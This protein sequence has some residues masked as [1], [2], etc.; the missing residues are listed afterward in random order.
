VGEFRPAKVKMTPPKTV[1]RGP[2]GDREA[3][4][5]TAPVT[6]VEDDALLLQDVVGNGNVNVI[7]SL[8]KMAREANLPR[9]PL[10]PRFNPESIVNDLRR[11]I[12][13]AET[14]PGLWVG[15]PSKD[16]VRKVDAAQVIRVLDNLRY[17]QIEMIKTLYAERLGRS[18]QKDPLEADLFEGGESG[19]P[20]TLKPDQVKRIKVLLQG[21][22]VD[23]PT[24]DTPENRLK[25][26]AIE[27]HELLNGDRD[28]PQL[29]RVMELLRRPEGEI[30]KIDLHYRITYEAEL[31]AVLEAKLS[32]PA[33]NRAAALRTGNLA[34]ADAWAIEEKRRKLMELAKAR[35][36]GVFQGAIQAER[37][38]LLAGIEEILELNRQEALRDPTNVG[39]SAAQAINDRLAA[40]LATATADQQTL[41]GQLSQTLGS[42]WV[43]SAVA[44]ADDG[45]AAGR[46]AARQLAA[47]E[48]M[49]TTDADKVSTLLVG[50]RE[51]ALHDVKARL[52]DPW[53]A[54]ADKEAIV[55]AG[56]GAIDAQV[57]PYIDEFVTHYEAIKGKGRPYD[58]IVAGAEDTY[59][60]NLLAAL[61]EGG[62]RVNPEKESTLDADALTV[63]VEA[64]NGDAVLAVLA[65]QTSREAVDVLEKKYNESHRDQPLDTALFG[66]RASPELAAKV[67]RMFTYAIVE[68]RT[69]T[70][71]HES[72]ER[73]R[74][75]GGIE[76]VAWMASFGQRE[77]TAAED[78]SGLI[79][80]AR[81]LWDDPETQTIMAESVQR[82]QALKAEW[83]RTADP[84]A[85]RA[86]PE[87]LAEM[88]RVRATLT[89]D[90]TAYESDNEQIAEQIRAAVNI[91]AQLA[92]AYFLPGLGQGLLRFLGSTAMNIGASVVVNAVTYRD[93]YDSDALLA[94]VSGGIFGTLGGVLGQ[95][96]LGRLAAKLA[97]RIEGATAKAAS[98]AGVVTAL[99]RE[100]GAG[101]RAAETAGAKGLAEEVG[102]RGFVTND[103]TALVGGLGLTSLIS[104]ENH[105]SAESLVVGLTASGAGRAGHRRQA[106]V[107]ARK[108]AA[109][110]G[111][112]PTATESPALVPDDAS[113]G[114][115]APIADS[116]PPE[117]GA[118]PDTA[119]TPE[120]PR[121]LPGGTDAVVAK[122]A[123]GATSEAASAE[124]RPS[125]GPIADGVVLERGPPV[126]GVG[127]NEV[128]PSTEAPATNE[129]RP[130]VEP[131]ASAPVAEQASPVGAPAEL[132]PAVEQKEFALRAGET[133]T[134]YEARLRAEEARLQPETEALLAEYQ[135]A[136]ERRR[137]AQRTVPSP[138]AEL[139]AERTA[140][141]AHRR[142]YNRLEDL[143]GR[144]RAVE[145]GATA[146]SRD[147]EAED[148]GKVDTCFA[149]GTPV[150][151]PGGPR[152]IES[153]SVNDEVLAWDDREG[154][155]VVRRVL[156]VNQGVSD[157]M[158]DVRIGTTRILATSQHPFWLA[159]ERAWRG[160]SDLRRGDVLRGVG[161]LVAVDS[162]AGQE[163]ISPTVNLHVDELHNYFAG[164]AG[165]LVHNGR[166][167]TSL[168][169]PDRTDTWIYKIEEWVAAG[170]YKTIYVGKTWDP[171]DERFKE[172][173]QEKSPQK[174]RWRALWEKSK[175]GAEPL[176]KATGI[177]KGKWTPAEVAVNER[178]FTE[179]EGG[180]A[181]GGGALENINEQ[182]S[183]DDFRALKRAGLLDNVCE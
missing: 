50:L 124:A 100:A 28:E 160:A 10:E 40:I 70:L 79:G 94:D 61:K 55:A 157:W 143:Q 123:I 57:Q 58:A 82:L 78:N 104:G 15:M 98:R 159:E 45:V 26:D 168:T 120:P 139:Q 175:P 85:P 27:L 153:L 183:N 142:A 156:A 60:R 34:A 18:H 3:R 92:L 135:K 11:A 6:V 129:A 69:A 9:P 125:T 133:L 39:K 96:V 140:Q 51:Q 116:L 24:G 93:R 150:H 41:G 127:P 174:A 91:A 13:Q 147:Y 74:V 83:I 155:T 102:L 181:N 172:H 33:R 89:G 101:V 177:R 137:K 75:L 169:S 136:L 103:V 81:G 154:R 63:A 110:V 87:I 138:A 164:E 23:W 62:G 90:A 162:V 99:S 165:V 144:L 180:R 12:D 77:R 14:I 118:L 31:S 115:S 141:L 112:P 53:L 163:T 80:W 152:A 176:I 182:I 46:L 29:A 97:S 88:R 68:G 32:G 113:T 121:A 54:T 167:N 2:R 119:A 132:A 16:D 20:S 7:A 66:L 44:P 17:T 171:V 148:I 173:L 64:R 67:G 65:K 19:Y 179:V 5:K 158:I 145:R 86:R 35:G 73:P 170:V 107:A 22:Q 117:S 84:W 95:Q 38:K 48:E 149:P 42:T 49:G 134:E 52:A 111:A 76:E 47:M 166:R 30:Q 130:S 146:R 1:L 131:V 126:D 151:T 56:E 109:E 8:Q 43:A 178:H 106:A 37:R 114:A 71:V 72:L 36:G 128:G 4:N 25:A 161:G 122:E 105:F 21:T 59:K 108:A